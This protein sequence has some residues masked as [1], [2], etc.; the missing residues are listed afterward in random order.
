VQLPERLDDALRDRLRCSV[1]RLGPSAT[2]SRERDCA[3]DG[4]GSAFRSPRAQRELSVSQS[5][6]LSE[7]QLRARLGVEGQL[8][9]N[10]F[11]TV[12][13]IE[14]FTSFVSG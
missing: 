1:R 13:F 4:D 10:S 5:E 7:L 14:R 3:R 12:T 11:G 6:P 9:L 8:K 2:V